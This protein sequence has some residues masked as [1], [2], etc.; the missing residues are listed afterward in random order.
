MD[1]NN[2]NSEHPLSVM[3][4][5]GIT[6]DSVSAYAQKYDLS[7]RDAANILILNELR[8][9]HWHLDFLH[10]LMYELGVKEGILRKPEIDNS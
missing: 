3:E 5:T 6:Y 8:C 7:I 9:M 2:G 10:G 1:G 4:T